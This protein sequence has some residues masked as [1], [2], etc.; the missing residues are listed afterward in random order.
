MN[1]IKEIASEFP[2]NYVV[3]LNHAG[4]GPWP[5]R[6]VRAIYDFAKENACY[7][8]MRSPNWSKRASEL[9]GV[10]AEL[11]N[12][13]N[14]D[15]IALLKNTSEALS[16]I[17][18]GIDWVNTDNIVVGMQE[19]PSNRIVWESL[20]HTK[21]VEIRV[22][23][24]Y[25]VDTPERALIEA[26]DKHTKLIAVS[27]IQYATGYRMDLDTL[28]QYC[29][30]HNILFCVDAIQS[31]GAAPLD[32]QSSCI[33][34]LAADAHKW[35]LAPEGIALFY[36]RN[37]HISKLKLNQYGWQSL[38]D[39]NNYDALYNEADKMKWQLK[40][41]AG[42]FECGSL[43]HLGIYALHASLSLLNEVGMQEVYKRVSQNATY[44]ANNLDKNRFALLTPNNEN[45]RGGIISCIALN[46]DNK[47]LFDY[48]IAQNIFCAYR[49]GGIRL[50]PH[51]YNTIKD[52]DSALELLHKYS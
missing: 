21:S 33:D 25:A 27:S 17:A 14:K 4:I 23:D 47:D 37:S 13:E 31:L 32:V 9:R 20:H 39:C 7:G 35:L 50:S 41:D 18:Y 26:T 44:I 11:I 3:H 51:F 45:Q 19:F 48:M 6:T 12:A 46:S 34:F 24:L 29:H 40:A 36:C 15:E 28:G 10:I 42:R 2:H 49:G 16:T 38:E 43:N 30:N 5:M 8:A 52:L 1:I 22:I